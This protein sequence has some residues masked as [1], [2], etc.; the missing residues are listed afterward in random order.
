MCVSNVET[1]LSLIIFP[2]WFD[3]MPTGEWW[4][5][6]LKHI[7]NLVMVY[8]ETPTKIFNQNITIPE[9]RSDVTRVEAILMIGKFLVLSFYLF[10]NLQIPLS[11]DHLEYKL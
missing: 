10:S 7:P 8:R 2:V 9:H 11:L 6:A 5:Y 1:N 3:S 4:E